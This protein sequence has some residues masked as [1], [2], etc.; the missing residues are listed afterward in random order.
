[1]TSQATTEKVDFEQLFRRVPELGIEVSAE[2]D[3]FSARL[4]PNPPTPWLR[5]GVSAV[6][7]LSVAGVVAWLAGDSAELRRLLFGSILIFGLLLSAFRAGKSF[8]PVEVAASADVFYFDG[9]RYPRAALGA[10]H[11]D[12]HDLVL[13]DPR[14]GELHR[15]VGIGP[16]VAAWLAEALAHWK[17]AT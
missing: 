7:W 11:L 10:F 3:G 1:M 13:C 16:S 5:I 8:M 4:Q 2:V 15:V 6:A 14:G 9:E 12:V 17:G